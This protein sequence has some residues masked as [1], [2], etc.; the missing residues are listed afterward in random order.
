MLQVERIPCASHKRMKRNMPKRCVSAQCTPTILRGCRHNSSSNCVVSFV[1]GAPW[2]QAH[3]A[4][5][6]A[7]PHGGVM[8]GYSS[9][10]DWSHSTYR[11][12]M[13]EKGRAG[14]QSS[15][16]YLEC[17]HLLARGGGHR[18]LSLQLHSG[19]CALCLQTTAR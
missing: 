17:L 16:H 14:G 15:H 10:L 4:F 7:C 1:K 3:M 6:A 18:R 19:H 9:M 5:S 12:C 8:T 2:H 11:E 13:Q